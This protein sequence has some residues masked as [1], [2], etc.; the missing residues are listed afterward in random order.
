MRTPICRRLGCELPIFA[1]SHCRDVIVEV[2]KAGGFGV[3]GAATISPEQL[4][5]ELRWID[6]HVNGRPYGV[7]VIIPSSYDS[8]AEQASDDPA[9]LIPQAHRD[10]MDGL[11]AA[12]GVPLLPPDEQARVHHEIAQGRGNMTPDGARRLVQVALRHPGVRMVVSALGAPPPDVV[13]EL[14]ARGIVIG[15][16]CGKPQHAVRQVAA[17]VEVVIAQGTE[18]GGHTGDIATLVLVPEVVRAC[19]PGVAV[20]AAGGISSGSQIAASLALGAQGVWCGTV[21][22]GTRESELAPFEK[23]RLFAARAEDAVRRRARTGKPVRMLKSKLSEAWEQAGAPAYLPTPLQGILYNEAHARVVRA[24][25]AD[26]YSFPVGQAVGSLHEET[27]V[28]EVML[29]LQTEYLDTMDRLVALH[30]AN[31]S[32]PTEP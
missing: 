3:L 20:L 5:T 24:E 32:E 11:L 7:D 8:A 27:S 21:W 23:A 2:T 13:A 30:P 22:L 14:Q 19:G 18:A 17:G 28:K 4:E 25:R 31:L 29:R 1:F 15:A 26:L 9:R 6:A 10:F 12:E 16:L